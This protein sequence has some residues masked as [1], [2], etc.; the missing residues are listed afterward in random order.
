MQPPT[1]P[2]PKAAS[3]PVNG[4]NSP[5]TSV[6][7]GRLLPPG[8]LPLP[9]ELELEL[10]AA[11]DR[12]TSAAASAVTASLIKHLSDDERPALQRTPGFSGV[13]AGQQ[14]DGLDFYQRLWDGE[15]ADLHQRARRPGVAEVAA[16]AP[17]DGPPGGHRSPGNPTR[18]DARQRRD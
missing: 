18:A 16:A 8:E 3:G 4:L 6:D 5:T 7:A 14:R 17:G 15:R 12:S 2:G 9:G 1:I 13:P 11:T 10:Q